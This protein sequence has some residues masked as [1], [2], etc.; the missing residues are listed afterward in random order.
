MTE[1]E[2]SS[3]FDEIINTYDIP[4]CREIIEHGCVSGVAHAHVYYHQTVEFFDKYEDEIAERL[5]DLYGVEFLVEL[6][7]QNDANLNSYKNDACWSY[8]ELIAT[9]IVDE[10]DGEN[11]E[12][13]N[14]D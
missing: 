5:I 7:K 9:E 3:A 2:F 1:S 12:G 13:S 10:V 8:I 11:E 4:T 14:D 6:F